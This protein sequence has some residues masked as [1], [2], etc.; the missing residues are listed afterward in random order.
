VKGGTCFTNKVRN[1]Y[2]CPNIAS[3]LL[4]SVSV[5]YL[6]RLLTYRHGFMMSM[7]V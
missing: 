6:G 5:L 2:L 1:R 4:V 7:R 3:K